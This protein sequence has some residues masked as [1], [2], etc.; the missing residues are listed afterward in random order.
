MG[1]FLRSRFV[2]H[3]LVFIGLC[4]ASFATFTY[5]WQ[6]SRSWPNPSTFAKTIKV[7]AM[8]FHAL[9]AFQSLLTWHSLRLT[10]KS[11]SFGL[12]ATFG[13]ASLVFDSWWFGLMVSRKG[14]EAVC[15]EDGGDCARKSITIAS[16]VYFGAYG[17]YRLFVL[18]V[19]FHF[20][21]HFNET[22]APTL[23]ASSASP[24]PSLF[25]FA[26]AP[27][28]MS[29][30]QWA[31]VPSP[32]PSPS[33]AGTQPAAARLH[34]LAK[35]LRPAWPSR[36][37]WAQ[38]A[39]WG[40]AAAPRS[41]GAR[42][43]GGGGGG[44]EGGVPLIAVSLHDDDDDDDHERTRAHGRDEDEAERGVLFDAD[45]GERSSKGGTGRR[46]SSELSSSSS[47]EEE[48]DDDDEP[49]AAYER[50]RAERRLGSSRG[51]PAPS[52]E[53]GA[54]ELEKQRGRYAA[55]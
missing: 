35:A 46:D 11:L 50:R 43:G 21:V 48:E 15:G 45:L 2:T 3:T 54:A 6:F 41:E 22:I 31:A 47:S 16:C 34:S 23:A 18:L 39:R 28:S 8:V 14:F 29:M 53:V 20:D 36:R 1:F 17:V 12:W 24:S 37:D 40:P 44:G 49:Q 5:A 52:A 32:S 27:P 38:L 55:V 25:S 9:F 4:C 33:V 30:A 10:S 26:P 13:L 7:F 19:V 51:S 42:R